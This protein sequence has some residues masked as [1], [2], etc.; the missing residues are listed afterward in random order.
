MSLRSFA[1]PA[2]ALLLA[3]VGAA[4]QAVGSS[5]QTGLGAAAAVGFES[6]SFSDAAQTGISR[7]SLLTVPFGVR[8][9]LPGAASLEFS[10]AYARGS[11]DRADGSS[12]SLQ[13]LTDSQLSLSL[14]VKRDVATITAVAIL[15]TGK[16]RMTADEAV[17]AGV[18][19]SELLPFRISNWGAGGAA[20]ASAALAHSF[21]AVGLGASAAYL[22]ARQYDLVEP[23]A[24]SYRP[25]NQLRARVA[26]DLSTGPAGKAS[27][28]LTY[29]HSQEDQFSGS[30]VFR[31]GDRFQAIGSYAFAAGQRASGIV[32][33]GVLHRAE[34]TYLAVV[35]STASAQNLF[36]AGG[37]ARIPLRGAVVLPS[38]DVRVLRRTSG[39]DQGEVVGIGGSAELPA[40][41]GV[42]FVPSLRARFGRVLVS[43]GSETG[44]NGF[45]LALGIRFGAGIQ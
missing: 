5:F 37:G 30:N 27:L 34:G 18:V 41:T 6:Y 3:P 45:D 11:L 29:L 36:L 28:Q 31:P 12:I 43:Q 40:T 8:T 26:L 4:A 7:M 32:Y 23:G 39:L 20:G 19:A 2:L 15:P 42:T 25:G 10:G 33:G 9:A 16:S 13:G 35:Q 14:P 24:F 22:V 17:V 1:V 44:F 21:G 38:L